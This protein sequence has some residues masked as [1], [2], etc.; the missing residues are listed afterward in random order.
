M[1]FTER[2]QT[3]RVDWPGHTAVTESLETDEQ[4]ECQAL[5]I[6]LCFLYVLTTRWFYQSTFLE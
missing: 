5:L 1:C 2:V 3:V 4:S 6:H